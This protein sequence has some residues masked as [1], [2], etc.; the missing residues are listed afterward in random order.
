LVEDHL[1]KNEAKTRTYF[2]AILFYERKSKHF[3]DELK[4]LK[5]AGVDPRLSIEEVIVFPRF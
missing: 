1:I 4:K 3:A 2:V 5:V